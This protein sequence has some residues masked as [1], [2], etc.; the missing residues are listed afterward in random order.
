MKKI[1]F[2]FFSFCCLTNIQA[3]DHK[4]TLQAGPEYDTNVFK[5]FNNPADDFLLRILGKYLTTLSSE[6]SQTSFNVQLGGKKYF[7][8]SE[9]DMIIASF[10][11]PVRF[12][13][14]DRSFLSFE[15]EF[16]Y[17]NERDLVDGNGAD[18]NEDFFSS[19]LNVNYLLQASAML[20][21][22][23][24]ASVNHFYFNKNSAFRFLRESGGLRVT[25]SPKKWFSMFSQYLFSPEQFTAIDRQDYEHALSSG[26]Q[27]THRL[28]FSGAYTYQK[29]LSSSDVFEFTSH[30]MNL[31]L[32]FPMLE[33]KNKE[34]LLSVHLLG[35]LQIR[36]YPSV[37]GSTV[38]GERF[39]LSGSED[40]NFNSFTAKLTLHATTHSAIEAKMTRYSNELS[41]A[42]ID[43]S[44]SLYYAGLR[45]IF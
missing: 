17:Q 14:G 7:N 24:L 45:Y 19:G 28:I 35:A 26:F 8:Q 5:N 25:L 15:P 22:N 9:Q 42:E 36:D 29:R 1:V 16:K 21:F 34:P 23:F 4:L 30:R 11:M 37:F 12:K 31:A 10:E 44:R 43:F 13:L 2:I 41:T 27:F 6:N 33:K 18:I 20:K 3:L 38:E 39:L 40:D 32:S